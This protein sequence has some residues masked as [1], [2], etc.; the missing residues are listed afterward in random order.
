VSL[1]SAE[2]AFRCLVLLKKA[3]KT[4]RWLLRHV[5]AIKG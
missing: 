5:D 1:V 3:N 4:Q 2:D